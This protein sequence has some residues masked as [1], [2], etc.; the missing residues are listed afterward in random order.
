MLVIFSGGSGVGK[1]TVIAELLKLEGFELLPTYTTRE[2][3][4]NETDGNP[5]FFITKAEFERKIEEN[6]FY[7]YEPVHGNYYGTSKKLLKEKRQTKNVLLKDIDVLGTRNLVN[8]IGEDIKLVTI[9]LK[10]A[11]KE[12]LVE[13]LTQRKE[14]EI[15]KRLSRYDMEQS[16]QYEYNY[17]ITNNDLETTKGLVLDIINFEKSA[18]ELYATKRTKWDKSHVY[19]HAERLKKGDMVAPIKVAIKEGKIYIIDGHHRYLASVM[20]G[21][22]I[23]KEVVFDSTFNELEQGPW[24]EA[25]AF[26]KNRL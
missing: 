5:Y 4:V 7:E 13:R 19:E 24:L 2:K 22:Q 9:F 8:R 15:E 11:S 1:N 21:I 23:A 14:K 20:T 26:A 6:E 16:H 12:V 25:I 10:V 17:I 18:G 3:R